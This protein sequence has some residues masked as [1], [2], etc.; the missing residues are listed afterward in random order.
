[1]MGALELDSNKIEPAIT[2]WMDVIVLSNG[3]ILFNIKRG[4][5]VTGRL[6]KMLQEFGLKC[7]QQFKSPC[8]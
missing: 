8:G 7:Q 4:P 3:K 1:M 2:Q 6:E 5:D